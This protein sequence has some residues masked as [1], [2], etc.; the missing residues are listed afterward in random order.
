MCQAE[1]I[2]IRADIFRGGEA[3]IATARGVAA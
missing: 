2:E 3:T 1:K